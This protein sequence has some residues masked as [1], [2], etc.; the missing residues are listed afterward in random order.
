MQSHEEE[1]I[2]VI[3]KPYICVRISLP[4]HI[5][6]L[7]R[8]RHTEKRSSCILTHQVVVVTS[9]EWGWRGRKDSFLTLHTSEQFNFHNMDVGFLIMRRKR[10]NINKK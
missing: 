8:Y 1:S 3:T 4:I 6:V 2:S 9:G 7:Y 5:F 10:L